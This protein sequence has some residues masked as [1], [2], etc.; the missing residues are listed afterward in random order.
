[1]DTARAISV[2]AVVVGV[3]GP[4]SAWSAPPTITDFA[5]CNAEAEDRTPS[6][7]AL[8]RDADERAAAPGTRGARASAPP[9]EGRP[10]LAGPPREPTDQ[11]GTLISGAAN[12]Q[13]E[14]MAAARANDP[15]YRAA[16]RSCMRRR[17]F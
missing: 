8:P 1:M 7:S 16:Y 6:P 13:L 17:G 10:G 14:G 12:P 15:E 5:T 4:A 3:L 9:P 11:S 2:L